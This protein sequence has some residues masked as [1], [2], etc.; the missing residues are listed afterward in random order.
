MALERNKLAAVVEDFAVTYRTGA[1]DHLQDRLAPDVTWQG[2]DPDLICRNRDEMM[3]VF[4]SQAK[5][6]FRL[7][8]LEVIEGG[9]TVVLCLRSTDVRDP[10]QTAL[11]FQVFTFEGDRIVRMEDFQSR[12]NALRAAGLAHRAAW[13]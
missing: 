4:R 3:H 9:D 13:G 11:I 1:V 12:G 10:G 5:E 6:S 7:D 8:Q 2:V